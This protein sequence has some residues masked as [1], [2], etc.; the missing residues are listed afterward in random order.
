MK[1]R[2]TPRYKE[3]VLQYF[4][5]ESR[6]WLDVPIEQDSKC[7]CSYGGTYQR[8]DEFQT[9]IYRCCRCNATKER[10]ER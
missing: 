4:H 6:E 5:E 2:Y 3:L 8:S 9:G 7:L 10:S 1:L